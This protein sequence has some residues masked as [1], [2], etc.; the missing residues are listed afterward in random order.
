MGEKAKEENLGIH[1]Y[2]TDV[3]LYWGKGREKRG[4][5]K[6]ERRETIKNSKPEEQKPQSVRPLLLRRGGERRA[7]TGVS[8]RRTS[9]WEK[10][11]RTIDRY[12]APALGC[13]RR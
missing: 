8:S 5:Q 3:L 1:I 12:D 7:K 2:A 13:R 4:R 6:K 9:I 11:G 10:D